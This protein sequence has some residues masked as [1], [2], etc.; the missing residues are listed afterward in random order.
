MEGGGGSSR[1]GIK[2]FD[3]YVGGK[4]GM[5]SWIAKEG[6]TVRYQLITTAEKAL[7][8]TREDGRRCVWRTTV[9]RGGH[10]VG[11][12]GLLALTAGWTM[13][14]LLAA[15]PAKSVGQQTGVS[16]IVGISVLGGVPLI[17]R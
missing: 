1:A 15:E 12:R 2:R 3:R 6:K 7:N 16:G 14:S 8:D 9:S 4:E 13:G 11:E 10:R 17:L 5:D